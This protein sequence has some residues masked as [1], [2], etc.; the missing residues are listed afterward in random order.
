MAESTEVQEWR[1][2]A[3]QLEMALRSEREKRLD[4]QTAAYSLVFVSLLAVA[5]TVMELE[6]WA[7]EWWKNVLWLILLWWGASLIVVPLVVLV[8]W[9]LKRMVRWWREDE[10]RLAFR[11]RP[12][13]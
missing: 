4:Y 3:T 1:R 13:P 8:Q 2:Y 7:D 12:E 11:N 10:D 5:V 9:P 6:G